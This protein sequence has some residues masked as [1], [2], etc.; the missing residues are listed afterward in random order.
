MK[1]FT[2]TL[3]AGLMIISLIACSA[4][5]GGG[6]NGGNETSA[7][8]SGDQETVAETVEL[9]NDQKLKNTLNDLPAA[10]YDGYEFVFLD[11]GVS[12]GRLSDWDTIDIYSSEMNGDPINDAVFERNSYVGEKYN[13]TI[14]ERK[15]SD[16]V[17]QA[18]KLILANEDS[19]DVVTD[20]ISQLAKTLAGEK[21]IIDYNEIPNVQLEKEWW[22]QS[23]KKGL[24]IM[25]KL[26][27]ATGDISIM[28]N[29]GTWCFMFNKGIIT[30]HSLD[31]PYKMVNNGTWTLDTMYSMAK[32]APQDIDGDGVMGE[33]DRY[34]FLSEQFNTYGLW[35]GSGE[36][37]ITKDANDMP[38]LTVYNDRSARVIDKVMEI[39]LDKTVTMAGERHRGGMVDGINKMYEQGLAL[40]IFGG[41]WL[42][43]KYRSS[44]VDFGILPTPKFTED[45]ENYYNTYSYGNC[46]MLSVPV[47]ASDISRTGMLLEAFAAISKYT[48][49]PAYMEISLKG[50]FLR[51][52]ESEGM[53]ELILDN[54]NYDLGALYD[55]GTCMSS[56]MTMYLSGKNDF[57]SRFAALEEKTLAAIDK[58][59]ALISE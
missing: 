14:S 33:W 57:A 18:R 38:T 47:T 43:S 9:T 40:F 31:D 15:V 30:D 44:E 23:I 34:G 55:W 56:F 20:G 6:G 36:K 4:G 10:D 58:Y 37:T 27:Y 21:L 3:L 12:G 26:Y 16:P 8:Q 45:Q 41:M 24:S 49:T 5:T 28:D 39:Q 32:T 25:R 29:Y 22:D 59:I 17:A 46:T 54:R 35:L 50:K 53:I 52:N 7:A 13:V 2:A 19:F 1:R 48:L 11:R 42:I 51:D